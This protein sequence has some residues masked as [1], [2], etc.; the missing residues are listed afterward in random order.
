MR[1]MRSHAVLKYGKTEPKGMSNIKSL[2]TLT[3]TD[4]RPSITFESPKLIKL[5]PVLWIE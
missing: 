1:V 2:K 4:F 5:F 3:L